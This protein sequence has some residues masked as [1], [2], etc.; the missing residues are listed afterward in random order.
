VLPNTSKVWEKEVKH[1][2]SSLLFLSSSV[3]GCSNQV[4]VLMLEVRGNEEESDYS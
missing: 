3:P 1:K 2:D 4:L